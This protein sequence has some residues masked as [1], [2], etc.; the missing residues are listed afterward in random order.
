LKFVAPLP[1]DQDLDLLRR[2]HPTLMSGLTFV[3]RATNWRTSDLIAWFEDAF[4]EPGYMEA[5]T[6]VS[7]PAFGTAPLHRAIRPKAIRPARVDDVPAIAARARGRVVEA[8]RGFLAT[9]CDDRFLQAAIFAERVQRVRIGSEAVWMPAPKDI[10]AL[11]NIAL[12]LFVVDVLTHREFYEANLC[13]CE[14]CGRVSFQPDV[15]G[16]RGCVR[17]APRTESISGF[18]SAAIPEDDFD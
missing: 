16:R 8:L 15:T 6:I 18:R 10:D 3:E 5:P 1:I 14:V 13:V 11:S 4:V 2:D 17:H 7:D 9:P 12:S